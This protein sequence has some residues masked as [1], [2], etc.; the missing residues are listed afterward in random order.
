MYHQGGPTSFLTRVIFRN[1]VKIFQLLL[2]DFKSGSY[3]WILLSRSHQIEDFH[4]QVENGEISAC[5]VALAANPTCLHQSSHHLSQLLHMRTFKDRLKGDEIRR[6]RRRLRFWCRQLT[7]TGSRF[8]PTLAR[9]LP[10]S[11]AGILPPSIAGILTAQFVRQHGFR[12]EAL[13]PVG[14]ESRHSSI[15][16]L[17]RVD[18]D[19]PE[20]P[21]ELLAVGLQIARIVDV[22]VVDELLH[23]LED[24]GVAARVAA[25]DL[26]LAETE[27]RVEQPGATLVT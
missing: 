19:L 20:F 12:N 21:L 17:P 1:F 8:P 15:P 23:Q 6:G 3:I 14:D 13:Q 18:S 4:E 9:I 26:Q 11:L 25:F 24:L 22:G 5:V 2:H 7:R 27:D 16:L 10:P